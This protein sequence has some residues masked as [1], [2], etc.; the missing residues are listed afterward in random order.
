MGNLAHILSSFT[1]LPSYRGYFGDE[2]KQAKP[3]QTPK[4][5]I[6]DEDDYRKLDP[7]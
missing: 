2:L 4:A 5:K 7:G 6:L 3:N 1:A